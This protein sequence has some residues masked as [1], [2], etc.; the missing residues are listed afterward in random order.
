MSE[1]CSDLV[2]GRM[3]F[4]EMIQT[5]DDNVRALVAGD[6]SECVLTGLHMLMPSTLPPDFVELWAHKGT[7]ALNTVLSQP[8]Y[9]TVATIAPLS[10]MALATLQHGVRSVLF[11]AIGTIDATRPA[12]EI[13][14]SLRLTIDN[15][16]LVVSV[17]ILTFIVATKPWHLFPAD[18]KPL[19]STVEHY[20]FGEAVA[21]LISTPHF[22]G[23]L[24]KADPD[25]PSKDVSVSR[26]EVAEIFRD[27]QAKTHQETIRKDNGYNA[28]ME[29][30]T[31]TKKTPPFR[32]G[33][34]SAITDMRDPVARTIASWLQQVK[35]NLGAAD[36]HP[37][38]PQPVT[39]DPWLISKATNAAAPSPAGALTHHQV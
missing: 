22:E 34:I 11:D 35:K 38:F 25:D 18:G 23:I 28:F 12:V 15:Q 20:S 37:Y 13:I 31:S 14:D 16:C 24:F 7:W 26:H 2:L 19:R 27:Q 4:E 21:E 17:S 36:A 10:S 33:L 30:F 9:L 1:S 5:I 29:S 6:T 8:K 39:T 3:S 32:E